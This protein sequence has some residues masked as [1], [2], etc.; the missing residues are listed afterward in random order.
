MSET[1]NTDTNRSLPVPPV[2]RD[3]QPDTPVFAEPGQPVS[4]EPAPVDAAQAD[5]AQYEA[6]QADAAAAQS[7]TSEPAAQAPA[8]PN[9]FSPAEAE[10]SAATASAAEPAV[11][12]SSDQV[13]T[14]EPPALVEPEPHRPVDA[15]DYTPGDYSTEPEPA[16]TPSEPQRTAVIDEVPVTAA[17]A[18]E[19]I[20]PAATAGAAPFAAG[21]AGVAGGAATAAAP[22][23]AYAA[24]QQRVFVEAPVAPTKRGNRII[25]TLI[26]V[27]SGLIFAVLYGAASAGL[28]IAI[29]P[30]G[31]DFGETVLRFVQDPIFWVPVI[32]FVV[33]FIIVVQLANRASW[34]AYVLGSLLVAAI[35][36]F[37]TIGVRLLGEDVISMT[38]AEALRAFVLTAVNPYLIVAAIIAREVAMWMGAP[39]AARGRRLRASNAEER[40]EYKTALAAHEAEY[41]RV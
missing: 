6:D 10:A 33:G 7:R 41:G 16:V 4:R 21:A 35:V 18:S 12:P 37:G 34:W 25:G 3:D 15:S 39:I 9:A 17:P 30:T 24:P 19:P 26:A 14:E 11:V 23:A 40:A 13:A 1:D 29:S 36:F 22:T 31:A 2:R 27:V 38:S 28:I 8:E 32:A 5:A 20:V